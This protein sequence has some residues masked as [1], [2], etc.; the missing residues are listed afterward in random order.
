M[1]YNIDDAIRRIPHHP[2]PGIL[3]YDLMPLFEDPA[4]LNACVASIAD[5]ARP[6]DIDVVLGA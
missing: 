5:W 6:R 1:T 4:G 3:F 2:R